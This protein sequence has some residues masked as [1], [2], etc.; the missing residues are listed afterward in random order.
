MCVE[1]SGEK[2]LY[3]TRRVAVYL[4]THDN[5]GSKR[6]FPTGVQLFTYLPAQRRTAATPTSVRLL[7][8]HDSARH[9]RQRLPKVW[10]ST[11][12]VRSV[13]SRGKTLN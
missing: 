3:K 8:R 9:D 12:L 13:Y 11:F 6:A 5:I 1:T 4:E 7:L 2:T 10:V